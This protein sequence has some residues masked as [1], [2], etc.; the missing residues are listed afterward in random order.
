MSNIKSEVVSSFTRNG[1]MYLVLEVDALQQ[2]G[3]QM[4]TERWP[5]IDWPPKFP[6]I[7]WP[8]WNDFKIDV[9]YVEGKVCMVISYKDKKWEHCI[10]ILEGCYQPGDIDIFSVG[11]VDVYLRYVNICP[12]EKGVNVS[13]QGWAKAGPVKTKLG[14]FSQDITA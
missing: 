9:T 14:T 11:P 7:S 13:F 4:Q 5:H 10:T 3:E 6:S 12:I 8:D 1:K 2:E